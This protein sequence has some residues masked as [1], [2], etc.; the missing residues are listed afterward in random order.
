MEKI[1][2]FSGYLAHY[3]FYVDALVEVIVDD[4]SCHVVI[5]GV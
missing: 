5:I 4:A 2:I 1:Q 3:L